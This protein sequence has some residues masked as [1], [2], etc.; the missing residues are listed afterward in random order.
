MQCADINDITLHYADTG[1]TSAT[2]L[3]FANSL[4]TDLRIWDGVVEQLVKI[5]GDKLRL[6][7]YDKRGH[8]LSGQT[9]APYDM[10][11][12]IDDLLS[13]LK[14]LDVSK[15]IIIGLSVG[16]MIAQGAAARLPEL[17]QAMVLSNTAHK[18]GNEEGWNARIA[19]IAENGIASL[20]QGVMELWFSKGFR[21]NDKA[22]VALYKNILERTTKQGYIGTCAALRDCD[23]T[24]ST[25]SLKLPVLLIAGSEDKAT[26][27]ALMRETHR[28][29]GAS[30]FEIIE[31]AG[32][33]PCVEKPE[34]TARLITQFLGDNSLV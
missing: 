26:P 8:G 23:L 2:T 10:D 18:I 16:G 14:H 7:R 1:A 25:G 27:P 19:T 11:T 3:V 29:I 9:A 28:L 15:C 24:K 31:G 33:L 22:Q 6:I 20:S 5:H 30:R 32:H 34:T 4:G 17:V 21:E 13:L 12:H